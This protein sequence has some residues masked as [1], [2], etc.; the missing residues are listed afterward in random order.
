MSSLWLPS[1][2]PLYLPPAKP[3]ARV[4]RTDDYV[5]PTDVYFYASSDR[6]LTVGHPYYNVKE[7]AQGTV[8]VPKVSANQYRVFRCR[9]PDPNRFALVDTKVY[10]PNTERLVWKIYG[11]EIKRGGPLGIGTTGHPYF[12]KVGD[13]ENPSIYPENGGVDQRMNCSFDPKQVQMF[14]VG[15]TPATGEFWDVAKPCNTLEKGSCPPIELVN[16]PIQDG[17]MGDLGFG[18]A[19]FRRFQEDKAGVP[20]DLVDTYSIWPDFLRMTSD[21]YGDAV[22]F[23]GKKEQM[24]ARHLWARNGTMGDAIPDD[25]SEFFLHPNGDNQ[26]K[27]GSFVYFPAPSGSLTTS[28]NQLFN[29][30]YW[31][32]R[33]QGTN[34]GICWGNDLFV[35]VYDNTR[36]T[37]FT[38][39]VLKENKTLNTSYQYTASDFKQYHRHV[40]EY[41][42]EFVF[43]L[44][45][46]QLNADILAHINVMNPRVLEDWNLA[47]VPPAPQGIEDAYRYL[48]SAATRCPPEETPEEAQ[49]PYKDLNFWIVDLREKFSSD[50][51]QYPLGR[52]FMYQLGYL[53][54]KR[55][56]TDYTVKPKKSVKRKRSK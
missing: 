26:N 36:G 44:C 11:L 56:R 46:V 34:N 55:V 23:W 14:I 40:E 20:L 7:N 53:N 15:C 33:A 4:L 2:G 21:I 1:A 6:L 18:A 38:I 52:K 17:D 30:P 8:T 10:D 29:K 50:L 24:F 13:T 54:G 41:E 43:Q 35:T 51:T 32:R 19:N 27:L 16:S 45:K 39:S 9:L 22:F 25:N 28:D 37:N 3:T 42:L 48:K 5:T 12:N 47:F 49:D 31:L